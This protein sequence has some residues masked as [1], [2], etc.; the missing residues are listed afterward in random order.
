MK[1]TLTPQDEEVLTMT[2]LEIDSRR[3]RLSGGLMRRDTHQFIASALTGTEPT[4]R[5]V[6]DFVKAHIR[7]ITDRKKR[8]RST[9]SS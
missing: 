9:Q 8:K 7:E 1:D 5:P 2:I 4:V 6:D 3:H